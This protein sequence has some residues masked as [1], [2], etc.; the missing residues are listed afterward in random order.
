MR[1]FARSS[2]R[3]R[4]TTASL[5]EPDKLQPSKG[6]SATRA[7]RRGCWAACNSWAPCRRGALNSRSLQVFNNG[8]GGGAQQCLPA[9]THREPAGMRREGSAMRRTPN[10]GRDCSRAIA[11]SIPPTGMQREERDM[12]KTR[13]IESGCLLGIARPA[14]LTLM[15]STRAGA[16]DGAPTPSTGKNCTRADTGFRRTITAS[17]CSSRAASVRF[18]GRRVVSS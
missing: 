1:A 5:Q 13:N 14:W 11:C 6:V 18:A 17:W 15:R 3:H 2:R 4:P 7:T 8:T 10:F 16:T 9:R 12:P